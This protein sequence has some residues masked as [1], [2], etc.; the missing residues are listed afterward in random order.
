[1]TLL[2]AA[3]RLL[4][5]FEP[6][7]RDRAVAEGSDA[8]AEWVMGQVWGHLEDVELAKA[9]LRTVLDDGSM[10]GLS[11]DMRKVLGAW[12]DGPNDGIAGY[13]GVAVM[14]ALARL[15]TGMSAVKARALENAHAGDPLRR[16]LQLT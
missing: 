12:P 9:V 6:T 8:V 3:S 10:L 14:V 7:D 2:V 4:G 1:M 13:S 5:L 11:E 16:V 15:V